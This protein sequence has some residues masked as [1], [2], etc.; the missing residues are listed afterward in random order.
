MA[1]IGVPHERWGETV[2]ALVVP[3]DA[4]AVS[5]RELV[6]YC[7]SKL[8][9]Y[10]CPDVDRVPHRARRIAI[11]GLQRYRFRSGSLPA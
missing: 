5:E 3:V 6:E 9:R 1:V 11:G 8:A 7:E 10:K 2:K 4:V